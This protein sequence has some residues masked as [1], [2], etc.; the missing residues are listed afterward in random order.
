MTQ[1]RLDVDRESQVTNRFTQAVDQ[2]GA[3]EEGL[4]NLEVRLGG[5]YTL[6]PIALDSPRDRSTIVEIF[7]A[8]VRKNAARGPVSS[9][10]SIPTTSSKN[11]SDCSRT[12]W[13]SVFL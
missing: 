3:A 6:E 12:R 4:P 2:L 11:A 5:I 9:R 7:T 10:A 13:R 8:Y 1:E